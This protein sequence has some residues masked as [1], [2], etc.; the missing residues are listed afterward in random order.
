MGMAFEAPNI[1]RGTYRFEPISD[2][3]IR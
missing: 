3:T 2:K 1:N